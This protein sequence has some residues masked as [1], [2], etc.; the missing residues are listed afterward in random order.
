M[1]TKQKYWW[2]LTIVAILIVRV[3]LHVSRSKETNGPKAD[4][5]TELA[6]IPFLKFTSHIIE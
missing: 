3:F 1:I 2:K 6:C 5:N 4:G